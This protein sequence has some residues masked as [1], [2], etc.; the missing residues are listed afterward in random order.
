MAPP[1]APPT[2]PAKVPAVAADAA[3]ATPPPSSLPPR[4]VSAADAEAAA[5]AMPRYFNRPGASRVVSLLTAP[6]ALPA[7]GVVVVMA[8]SWAALG[9]RSRRGGSGAGTS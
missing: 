7:A 4:G 3:A 5:A 8:L 1:A 2:P 6:L 9:G